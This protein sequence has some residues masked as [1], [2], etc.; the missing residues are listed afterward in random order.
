MSM[1]KIYVKMIIF[2]NKSTNFVKSIYIQP[3]VK[4][5]FSDKKKLELSKN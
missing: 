5:F 4:Q 1:I 3:I 2:V